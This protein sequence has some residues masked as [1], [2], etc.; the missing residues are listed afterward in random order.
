MDTTAV[1][2]ITEA[3]RR[4][5]TDEGLFILEKVIPDDHLAIIRRACAHLIDVMHAEMDR[6]GTDHIH[7]SHR[8]KR[9]HIAKQYRHAPRLDEF[10]FSD[11]MAN[12][13]KAA[14]RNLL[15]RGG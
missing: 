5:Y 7:I 1:S 9:Y 2:P 12:I 13:C 8:N 3:H 4:R 6:L 11:L 14:L 15:V 10:V